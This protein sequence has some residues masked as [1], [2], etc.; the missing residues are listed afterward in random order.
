M[1]KKAMFA[2]IRQLMD[3]SAVQKHQAVTAK[4]PKAA[5]QIFQSSEHDGASQQ[6]MP[7]KMQVDHLENSCAHAH[8]ATRA[9][10]VPVAPDWPRWQG[11]LAQ[12]P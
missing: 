8:I 10:D 4:P 6:T 11:S 2:Q 3:S 12:K 7:S 5:M 1:T 9:G